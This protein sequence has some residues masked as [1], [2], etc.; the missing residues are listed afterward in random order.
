MMMMWSRNEIVFAIRADE[1]E[2]EDDDDDVCENDHQAN[3]TQRAL[4]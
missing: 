1:N 3:K 4:A 2:D